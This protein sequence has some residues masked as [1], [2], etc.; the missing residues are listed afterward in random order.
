MNI[1][2][3]IKKEYPKN[4]YKRTSELLS[5]SIFK[6]KKIIKNNNII[7]GDRDRRVD[8]SNFENIDKK[9]VAYFLGFFWSDGYISRDEIT[10]SIKYDDEFDILSVLN[11]FGN[12]RVSNRV[13]KLKTKEFKQSCI[14][15]NDRFIKNFLIDND[16]DK[17]SITT[18]TKILSKIPGDIKNYFFRGLIDG[19]GCFCSK[20][21]NYFSITGNINQNWGEIQNLLEKLDINYSLTKKERTSGNSSYIVISSKLEIIKLGKYLY[22]DLYD[23]I[24]LKRK[25]KIYEEIKNKP[26][27]KNKGSKHINRFIDLSFNI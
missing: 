6:L 19:D 23:N 12:W 13:K 18:P 26:T 21:R 3:F 25:Y 22:G 16:F 8:I 11:T 2:D 24:G 15:I 17:K 5:I 4:G 10:M 7:L 9:E 20:N 14:R 27:L 1:V